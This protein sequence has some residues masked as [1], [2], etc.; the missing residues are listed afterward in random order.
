MG[1]GVYR[2]CK[3]YFAEAL[4]ALTPLRERQ[5]IEIECLQA[6]EDFRYGRTLC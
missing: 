3:R 1:T 2:T 6:A 5:H 4:C